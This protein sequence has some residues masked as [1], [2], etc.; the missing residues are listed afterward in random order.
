MPWGEGGGCS[1][2]CSVSGCFPPSGL[3]WYIFVFFIV[4]NDTDE[5]KLNLNFS[6]DPGERQLLYRSLNSKNL[7]FKGGLH[8][9]IFK[10]F[11]VFSFS[12]FNICRVFI[13]SVFVFSRHVL[14]CP[15]SS[16][17][18]QYS[19]VERLAD[20]ISRLGLA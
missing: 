2:V 6:I 10:V 15:E 1:W 16:M 8:F 11:R 19:W 18:S 17:V 20:T 13:L 5:V 7:N 12:V 3:I 14:D 4:T 9:P